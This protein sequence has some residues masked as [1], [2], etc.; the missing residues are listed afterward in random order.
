[1]M[2]MMSSSSFFC[3]MIN[4]NFSCW[5][6]CFLHVSLLVSGHIHPYIYIHTYIF[7]CIQICFLSLG[8]FLFF[9]LKHKKYIMFFCGK[10]KKECFFSDFLFSFSHELIPHQDDEIHAC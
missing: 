2:M 3:F 4:N 9:L 6:L 1:M 8:F 10:R 5:I 7:I